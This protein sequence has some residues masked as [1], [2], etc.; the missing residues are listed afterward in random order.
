MRLRSLLAVVL[1]AAGTGTTAAQ[2]RV[3][4]GTRLAE[5]PAAPGPVATPFP[6]SHVGVQWVGD[7]DPVVEVRTGIPGQLGPWR[8]L[9]VAHDLDDEEAGIR[10]SG[11]VRADG[12][13]LVQA[14][15]GGPARDIRIVAI[16][17]TSSA[18]PGTRPV[19]G[20]GSAQPEVVSRAAWGADEGMRTGT[21]EFATPTKLVVHHTVTPN[22]DPDPAS[23]VRAIYAYHTR[24]NGWNDI[25]Y[26]FLVDASGRVYEGRYARPYGPGETPT[27]EDPDGRGVIG[28]HARGFNV[29]SVGVALLGDFSGAAEPTG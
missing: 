16:D 21:P 27:G 29:G 4:S 26:N 24:Q 12:A 3:P 5:L 7:D 9:H 6:L 10:R 15:T 18:A 25:G 22:D 23:T 20:P 28:A 2:S 19:G 17:A 1:I 13:T 14:R 11:L 8:R